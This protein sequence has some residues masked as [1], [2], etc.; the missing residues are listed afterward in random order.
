M[1]MKTH[2][3]ELQRLKSAIST[4]HGEVVIRADLL[5][6]VQPPKDEGE[7]TST[8]RMSEANARVLLSLLKTQML[9]FDKR[10]ARS[11]R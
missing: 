1:S 8:L 6:T 2:Q 11:Q 5:V 3:I 9:E 4:Q 10:K 7:P